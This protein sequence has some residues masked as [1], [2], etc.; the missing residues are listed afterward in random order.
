MSFFSA[1][2]DRLL[3]EH[4]MSPADLARKTDIPANYISR[5]RAGTRAEPEPLEKIARAFGDDGADLI[6]AWLRDSVPDSYRTRISIT[7]T[8][9]VRE[10]PP[11]PWERLSAGERKVFEQLVR[12]VQENPKLLPLLQQVITATQ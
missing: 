11:N 10:E 12:R 4:D 3:P 7:A 1:A 6:L 2:L 5:Y 9:S 8:R